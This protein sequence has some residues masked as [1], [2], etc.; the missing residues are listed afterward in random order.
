MMELEDA[1]CLLLGKHR[2]FHAV[3]PRAP[4]IHTGQIGDITA[5]DLNRQISLQR[6]LASQQKEEPSICITQLK[7]TVVAAL[8]SKARSLRNSEHS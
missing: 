3:R 8:K 5:Y 6:M 7:V 1:T 2:P 4:A